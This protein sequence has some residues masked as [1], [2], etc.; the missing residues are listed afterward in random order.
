MDRVQALKTLLTLQSSPSE[1][2]IKNIEEKLNIK[3]REGQRYII[4]QTV[5]HLVNAGFQPR[6]IAISAPT[7]LGKT[8]TSL[9][10]YAIIRNYAGKDMANIVAVRTRNQLMCFVRDIYKFFNVFPSVCLAKEAVCKYPEPELQRC[11]ECALYKVTC[12]REDYETIV[13]IVNEYKIFDPY[14][15]AEKFFEIRKVC[16]YR[17]FTNASEYLMTELG[18]EYQWI[19]ATYPYFLR[20]FLVEKLYDFVEIRGDVVWTV[21][22]AHNLE[23]FLLIPDVSISLTTVEQAIAEARLVQHDI[24]DIYGSEVYKRLIKLLKY[25]RE[26][27]AREVDDEVVLSPRFEHDIYEEFADQDRTLL[28]DIVGACKCGAN[29]M[30]AKLQ[31]GKGRRRRIALMKIHKLLKVLFFKIDAETT[32]GDSALEDIVFVQ[33]EN[34]LEVRRTN[35]TVLFERYMKSKLE[36]NNYIILMS[37]TLP[38][39]EYLTNIWGIPQDKLIYIDASSYRIGQ[40]SYI[41]VTS[42]TSK[43]EERSEEMYRKY[44]WELYKIYR[45]ARKHVLALAPSYGFA[46]EVYKYLK[47]HVPESKI[48][49]E[50]R[51]TRIGDV[52]ERA[53]RED[54]LIIIAVAGGKISEGV[55]LVKNDHSLISDVVILGI[56]Y[57]RPT[58]YWRLV[59]SKILAKL[60]YGGVWLYRTVQ[61]WVKIRQ[62]LGRGIRHPEDTCT[63]WLLDARFR[64]RTWLTLISRD[65]VPVKTVQEA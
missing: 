63:W 30:L 27:L 40:A 49:I 64:T 47:E 36:A 19:I 21:D 3:L 12:E 53:I 2:I 39:Q 9:L 22:E 5:T 58:S 14:L 38:D 15:V 43:Y 1:N 51:R 8:L 33:S 24:V 52:E 7:G 45:Q 10:L 13:K 16:P 31:E 41:I 59:E 32:S 29:H 25:I 20:D 35:P 17:I 28:E 54:K 11:A 61:A 4:S 65:K 56:P 26:L 62:A 44:A 48:I 55:E 18:V 42:V 60:G 37:G 50:D 34:R 46:I 23:Q 57:P 6:I